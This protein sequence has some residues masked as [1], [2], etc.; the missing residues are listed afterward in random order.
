MTEGSGSVFAV[1][2][3]QNSRNHHSHGTCMLLEQQFG[4][5]P[6]AK[7]S[8]KLT[9]R[10]S[11]SSSK[12]ENSDTR[13]VCANMQPWHGTSAHTHRAHNWPLVWWESIAHSHECDWSSIH[14]HNSIFCTV[15]SSSLITEPQLEPL[16]DYKVQHQS[17]TSF[18]PGRT[19]EGSSGMN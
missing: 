17:R 4:M 12:S 15:K 13:V 6:V 5:E 9:Q 19:L 18:H 11:I 10:H 7:C 14:S 3:T 8:R 2:A 16:L 1:V